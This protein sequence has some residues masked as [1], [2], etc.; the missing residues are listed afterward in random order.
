MMSMI[1][2][3]GVMMML[4]NILSLRPKATYKMGEDGGDVKLR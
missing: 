4:I 3:N 2:R 1:K